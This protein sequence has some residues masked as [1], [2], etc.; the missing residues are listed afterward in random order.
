MNRLLRLYPQAW[1]ARY[2]PELDEIVGSRPLGLGGSIDL[3]LGAIDAHRHPELVDP[4]AEPAVG[5]APVSRQRYEDL[6]VARRL[7]RAAWLGAVLW[8]GGLAIWTTGPI[9]RDAAGSYRD[10]SAAWPLLFGAMVALA[11]GM[12]GQ[13]VRLPPGSRLARAGAFAALIAWP[14]WGLAPWVMVSG[15]VGI[16]GTVLLA[17]GARLAGAWG[18]R[19]SIA[20]CAA[21]A[22][23]AAGM[24]VSLAGP[25]AGRATELL[26]PLTIAFLALTPAWLAVGATLQALPPVEP[27]AT[28]PIGARVGP[29]G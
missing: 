29:A 19:A 21:V 28:V 5:L 20:T 27:A 6:R 7:G 25:G 24:A 11:A 4:S 16:V 22:T 1:L 9:V 14:L 12:L 10:G 18:W 2:G 23:M 15:V 13:L 8:V 3:V 17:V 26:D